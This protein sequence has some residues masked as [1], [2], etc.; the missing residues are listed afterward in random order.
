MAGVPH[1]AAHSYP[2]TDI[3]GYKV[4]IAQQME[5]PAEAKGLVKEQSPIITQGTNFDNDENER[6]I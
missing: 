3:K 4:A 6:L 5:D 2:T 1:H